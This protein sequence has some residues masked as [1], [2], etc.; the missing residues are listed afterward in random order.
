MFDLFP[1]F[2]NKFMYKL[3]EEMITLNAKLL[4]T[5]FGF[6]GQIK[7]LYMGWATV[8][9]KNGGANVISW[10]LDQQ[11]KNLKLTSIFYYSSPLVGHPKNKGTK[12]KWVARVICMQSFL[13]HINPRMLFQSVIVVMREANIAGATKK[14]ICL[15]RKE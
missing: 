11:C 13:V 15:M 12:V 2:K 9:A 7:D 1:V 3:C 6:L 4:L 10:H 8:A 14:I 5:W